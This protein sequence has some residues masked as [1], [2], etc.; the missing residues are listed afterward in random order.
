MRGRDCPLNV[1]GISVGVRP[2]RRAMF[3]HL[4]WLSF[5]ATGINPMVQHVRDL[6]CRTP[7]F[8]RPPGEIGRINCQWLLVVVQDPSGGQN[9]I[10]SGWSIHAR[11]PSRLRLCGGKR[12]LRNNVPGSDPV[13]TQPLNHFTAAL[14]V[15]VEIADKPLVHILGRERDPRFG[16][17]V[18]NDFKTVH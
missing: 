11:V 7:Q 1:I 18:C 9:R 8:A 12:W 2:P 16:V 13:L 5:V 4:N 17:T 6:T 15:Q 14:H 10:K 3:A